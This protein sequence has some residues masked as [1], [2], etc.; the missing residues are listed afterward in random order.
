MKKRI[1]MFILF[2]LFFLFAF[3]NV[4]ASLEKAIRSLTEKSQNLDNRLAQLEQKLAEMEKK[5]VGASSIHW[6][7]NKEKTTLNILK[8]G[9]ELILKRR[10]KEAIKC[11]EKVLK[12]DSDYAFF[13]YYNL[14]YIYAQFKDYLKAAKYFEKSLQIKEDKDVYY[15]LAVIYLHYL[16]NP[17]RAQDYYL[18][19][20]SKK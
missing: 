11:F 12:E 13:A 19:Y 2:F 20:L 3:N 16:N 17:R 15:N 4:Y 7:E 5:L 18:K 6:K 10:Y 1:K 14:G 8:K 9:Y